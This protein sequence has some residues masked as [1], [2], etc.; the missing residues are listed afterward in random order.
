ML[1][2]DFEISNSLFSTLN[3][4]AFE[5]GIY[6]MKIQTDNGVKFAKKIIRQ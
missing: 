5:R 1:K 2:K 6:F 3:T 4:E